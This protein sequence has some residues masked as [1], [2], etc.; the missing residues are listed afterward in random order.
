M[1]NI[2]RLLSQE[3][4]GGRQLTITWAPLIDRA[5]E[6][7]IKAQATGGTTSK[8]AVDHR[9]LMG[10]RTSMAEGMT[11]GDQDQDTREAGVATE[12]EG[13]EVEETEETG[14]LR[15]GLVEESFE[16]GE[17]TGE[18]LPSAYLPNIYVLV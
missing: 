4:P 11:A 18:S 5:L 15:K 2:C 3:T 12:G 14:A 7:R 13:T 1:H 10:V 9:T 16:G 8:V 6:D 17:R